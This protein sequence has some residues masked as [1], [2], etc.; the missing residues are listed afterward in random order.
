M[1]YWTAGKIRAALANIPDDEAVAAWLITRNDVKCLEDASPSPAK[2]E[3]GVNDWEAEQEQ[4]DDYL[5]QSLMER[6][7]DDEEEA[8]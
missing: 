7:P 3:A 1:A 2:W 8:E 6:F 4:G 5:Y